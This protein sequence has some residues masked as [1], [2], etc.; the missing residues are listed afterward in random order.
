MKKS[1]KFIALLMALITLL[2]CQT[3]ALAAVST[4]KYTGYKYTHQSRFNNRKILNGIDVSEF[5]GS[6]NF[7]KVKADGIDF[8]FVRVGYTGYTR[9]KF[10]LNY[11]A[12]YKKNIK[13]ALANGLA[14]GVYWYSQATSK[15]EAMAEADRITVLRFLL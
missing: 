8:V 1:T 14:V 2:S 4:S 9:S 12:Y 5:N 11:D 15:K 3:A 13:N 6:I 10:S 7:K